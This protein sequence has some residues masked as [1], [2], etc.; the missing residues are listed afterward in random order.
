MASREPT[1]PW[2]HPRARHTGETHDIC[3]D[4][5]P[6]YGRPPTPAP[7]AYDRRRSPGPSGQHN[8][9][10]LAEDAAAPPVRTQ[11]S[12][13]AFLKRQTRP[14]LCPGIAFEMT[15]V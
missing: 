3:S 4:P 13:S 12:T 9:T 6:W 1:V 7:G 11:A 5:P 15:Q 10:R 8:P 2:E 14:I